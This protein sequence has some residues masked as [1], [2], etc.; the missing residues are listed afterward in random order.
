MSDA[1]DATGDG[2]KMHVDE[3]VIV[4]RFTDTTAFS[5]SERNEM[6]AAFFD[7][8]EDP[9]VDAHVAVLEMEG[10][11]GDRLLDGAEKV[12]AEVS[13]EGLDRWAVV[14]DGIKKLAVKGRIDDPDVVLEGFEDPEAAIEWAKS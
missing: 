7:L 12:A 8:L 5:E 10:A 9:A 6:H 1:A 3:T 14:D 11:A 4:T 2:W 13:D